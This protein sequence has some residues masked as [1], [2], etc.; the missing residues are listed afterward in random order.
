M[1][2]RDRFRNGRKTEAQWARSGHRQ[3]L[4]MA[5]REVFDDRTIPRPTPPVRM[6]RRH[7]L[8]MAKRLA[9][10]YRN[11][12]PCVTTITV[13]GTLTTVL[14]DRRYAVICDE[15][16]IINAKDWSE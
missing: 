4:R 16:S 9:K 13:T 3:A 8:R 1:G 12:R 7:W 5:R 14:R 10:R 6:S 2:N 15:A 11:L